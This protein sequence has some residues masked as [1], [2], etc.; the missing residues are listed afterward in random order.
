MWTPSASLPVNVKRIGRGTT[1]QFSFSTDVTTTSVEIAMFS[2]PTTPIEAMFGS[3]EKT[4]V[5]GRAKPCSTS[6]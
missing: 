5:P 1:I 3:S 2:A 4:S 6:T